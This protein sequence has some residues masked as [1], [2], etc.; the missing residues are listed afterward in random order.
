MGHHAERCWN[1][2]VPESCFPQLRFA[3][4]PIFSGKPLVVETEQAAILQVGRRHAPPA[5]KV[6]IDEILD[7]SGQGVAGT[8]A[9]GSAYL[10]VGGVVL[11]WQIHG[12]DDGTRQGAMT[13]TCLRSL[14]TCVV[15]C[16]A[17][18]R[19][20]HK[21]IEV[22]RLQG[23]ILSVISKAQQLA[24]FG[25]QLPGDLQ[26]DE[27]LDRQN[28]GGRAP[29]VHSEGRQLETLR[30]LTPGVRYA[31]RRFQAEQKWITDQRGRHA[32]ALWYEASGGVDEHGIRNVSAGV[33][34]YP[35][36]VARGRFFK[37]VGQAVEFRGIAC[38]RPG[39]CVR[40]VQVS[41][42]N[43]V[44]SMLATVVAWERDSALLV[45]FYADAVVGGS[46]VAAEHQR[47]QRFVGIA[48]FGSLLGDLQVPVRLRLE[49]CPHRISTGQELVEPEGKDREAARLVLAKC[50]PH[51][52]PAS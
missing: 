15:E 21:V 47:I 36:S 12:C 17:Q 25:V 18:K 32:V 27:R 46:A 13:K 45:I 48:G 19:D 20:L 5:F 49:R 28:G 2:V 44:V 52:Q 6:A 4:E 9:R 41:F 10:R 8:L 1:F 3:E 14:C 38:S 31:A 24:R 50:R 7:H 26:L 35:F 11:K 39:G 40:D 16:R 42:L 51:E 23:G 34:A 29:I 30:S 43:A 37:Q 33:R 22:A